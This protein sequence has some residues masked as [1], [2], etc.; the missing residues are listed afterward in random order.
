MLKVKFKNLLKN[1][2]I[3]N[4]KNLTLKDFRNFT[5]YS[6]NLTPKNG[7][8]I[9]YGNNGTGKSAILEAICLGL[10]KKSFRINHNLARVVRYHQEECTITLTCTDNDTNYDYE[11]VY[12]IKT[13]GVTNHTSTLST[14]LMP[15]QIISNEDFKLLLTRMGR[16]ALVD[17]LTRH[18]YSEFIE[19]Y[20]HYHHLLKQRNFML[21]SNL[22]YSK[23][24]SNLEH[25]DGSLDKYANN[26]TNQRFNT[27]KSLEKSLNE[28]IQQK[29]SIEFYPGYCID[30]GLKSCLSNQKNDFYR[31]KFTNYGIHLARINFIIDDHNIV[32]YY[33]RGQLK[34][35]LI[36][37]KLARNLLV[38][39]KSL[40][41]ID[42]LG[43]ELDEKS[44]TKIIKSFMTNSVGVYITSLSKAP[45]NSKFNIIKLSNS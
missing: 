23:L 21:N 43:S 26:I 18:N 27:I 41:L 14:K 4:L 29:I 3:F 7:C 36:N 10:T 34:N 30:R 33:S 24:Q 42:D 20:S 5:N 35:F 9:I 13:S 1:L 31:S 32:D 45:N 15:I 28:I 17:W 2:V 25:I 16:C 40:A 39:H 38:H 6:C 44:T 11:S 19:D 12:N 22:T 37:F 8:T